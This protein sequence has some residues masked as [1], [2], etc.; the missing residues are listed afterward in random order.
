MVSRLTPACAAPSDTVNQFFMVSSA[1]SHV[2]SET[3][4]VVRWVFRAR[5]RRLRPARLHWRR[6]GKYVA[7]QT[8]QTMGA[9]GVETI[10]AIAVVHNQSLRLR[11]MSVEVNNAAT[12]ERVL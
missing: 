7:H 10:S 2:A 9:R 11:A 1:R 12:G 4:D 5:A 8:A 6:C 3:I